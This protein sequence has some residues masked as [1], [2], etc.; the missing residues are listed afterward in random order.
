VLEELEASGAEYDVVA[1]AS[2]LRV[3]YLTIH[4]ELDEAV[5]AQEARRLGD[6]A[7]SAE[8]RISIVSRAGHTFGA[9]HPWAG[10]TAA[11]EQAVGETADWFVRHLGAQ[12]RDQAGSEPM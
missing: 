12:L 3:P 5:A 10:P 7:G 11:W 2:R 1:A 9:A 4:G 6:A 8:K